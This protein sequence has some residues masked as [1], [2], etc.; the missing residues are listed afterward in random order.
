MVDLLVSGHLTQ[1]T[2]LNTMILVWGIWIVS[3]FPSFLLHLHILVFYLINRFII[4]ISRCM[5]ELICMIYSKVR[6]GLVIVK[7]CRALANELYN[8]L[9]WNCSLSPISLSFAF[10]GRLTVYA[11]SRVLLHIW[12]EIDIIYLYCK[13]LQSLKNNKV[14]LG[15]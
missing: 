10:I 2:S 3:S 7:Y 1:S 12:L 15:L 4:T 11:F 6:S 13:W 14:F 8:V 5:H 9:S